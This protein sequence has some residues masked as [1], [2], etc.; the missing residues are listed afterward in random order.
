MK[1]EGNMLEDEEYNAIA[2]NLARYSVVGDT[3]EYGEF[4]SVLERKFP[5]FMMGAPRLLQSTKSKNVL[6][7]RN[8]YVPPISTQVLRSFLVKELKLCE[9][10]HFRFHKLLNAC[11]ST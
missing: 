10:V 2:A 3:E 5:S 11:Q 7:S 1:E 8:E 9:A 4:L 6:K